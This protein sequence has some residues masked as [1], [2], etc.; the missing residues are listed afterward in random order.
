MSLTGCVAIPLGG[1][2]PHAHSMRWTGSSEHPLVEINLDVHRHHRRASFSAVLARCVIL[3]EPLDN[4]RRTVPPTGPDAGAKLQVLAASRQT[5][6]RPEAAPD[7]LGPK[8]V[9]GGDSEDRGEAGGDGEARVGAVLPNEPHADRR[10]WAVRVYPDAILGLTR[11]LRRDNFRVFRHEFGVMVRDER[12][13]RV[14][15]NR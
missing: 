11:G 5:V 7:G 15:K 9:G 2:C 8:G 10:A 6:V 1:Q 3:I 12:W 13:V 14:S 4:H